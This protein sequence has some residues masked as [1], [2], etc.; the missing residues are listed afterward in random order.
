MGR[1]KRDSDEIVDA[2]GDATRRGGRGFQQRQRG[3]SDGVRD[4][5]RAVQ[6]KD[7]EL[8]DVDVPATDRPPSDSGADSSGGDGVDH[9]V[10]E[11]ASQIA[12]GHAYTD[13]V[14]DD[15]QFPGVESPEQFAAVI[16]DVM[17]NGL[18]NR[19][20][21][22]RTGYWYQDIFVVRDPFHPDGGSA[23]RPS[24]G[25]NHFLTQR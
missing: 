8:G 7:G 19:L 6:D 22:G 13:H 1:Q 20:A 18:S 3:Q 17:R 11:V 16:A 23:Y 5:N 15:Q 10:D 24:A 12:H 14:V 25:F 4:R 9:D 2:A 21:R